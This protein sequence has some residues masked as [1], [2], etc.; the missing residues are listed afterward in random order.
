MS[1][2]NNPDLP[3]ILRVNPRIWW[4]WDPVPPWL[5]PGLDRVKLGDLAVVAIEAQKAVLKV[6]M[7]ALDKSIAIVK[8]AK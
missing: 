8:R 6:Q 2:P 3:D 7:E 5:I 4:I 1:S